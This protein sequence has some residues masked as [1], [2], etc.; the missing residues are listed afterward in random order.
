MQYKE[1]ELDEKGNKIID[2][3]EEYFENEEGKK[4]YKNK[5]NNELKYEENKR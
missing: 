5:N 2:R 4:L 3:I 1:Y